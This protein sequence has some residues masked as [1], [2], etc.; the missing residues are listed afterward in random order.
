[1]NQKVEEA[2]AAVS[3]KRNRS[4]SPPP[5]LPVINVLTCLHPSCVCVCAFLQ[6]VPVI[7]KTTGEGDE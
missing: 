7:I 5:S 4:F 1:M 2:E 3:L 6:V